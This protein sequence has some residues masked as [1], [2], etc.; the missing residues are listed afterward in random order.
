ML[1]DALPMLLKAHASPV[2]DA[3]KAVEHD[4][5]ATRAMQFFFTISLDPDEYVLVM[6]LPMIR[7][8]ACF[9]L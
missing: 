5:A 3:A 7:V 1:E 8:K 6:T 9:L 2:F 4:V